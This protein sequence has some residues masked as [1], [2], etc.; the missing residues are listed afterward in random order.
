MC[1]EDLLFN[2]YNAGL[3]VLCKKLHIWM[4]DR[5]NLSPLGDPWSPL[6][7]TMMGLELPLRWLHRQ[8]TWSLIVWGLTVTIE[9]IMWLY[10]G[11]SSHD[12][13]FLMWLLTN[14][15]LRSLIAVTRWIAINL[16]PRWTRNPKVI[17]EEPRCHPTPH[18]R[19]QLRHKVPI[20]YNATPHIYPICPFPSTI[21]API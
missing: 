18:D 12:V 15:K 17:W 8:I 3:W 14:P 7:P 1:D 21:T 16:L 20:S 5:Q 10:V 19:G 11:Y 2:D 9:P 13:S 4:Y 6:A